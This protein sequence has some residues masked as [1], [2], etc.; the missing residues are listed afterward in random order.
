MNTI[1]FVYYCSEF[2]LSIYKKNSQITK[3]IYLLQDL[4]RFPLH[5][6]DIQNSKNKNEKLYILFIIKSTYLYMKA[7]L[8]FFH[9]ISEGGIIKVM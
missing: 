8:N 5:F 7:Q 6:I 1:L 3:Q 2:N 9:S 4:V